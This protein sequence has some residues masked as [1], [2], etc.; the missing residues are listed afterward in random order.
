MHIPPL[1]LL[2]QVIDEGKLGLLRE[3][4]SQWP[5][6]SVTLD[7]MEMVFAKADPRVAE[8]YEMM[9]VD[10]NL[11]E[12]GRDLRRCGNCDASMAGQQVAA[13]TAEKYAP[14]KWDLCR[15]SLRGSRSSG[16]CLRLD[17]R[18]PGGRIMPF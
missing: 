13:C 15:C 3:M 16:A 17:V 6:F 18:V 12:F 8:F 11:W 10:K 9:L 7:M 2:Q 1:A 4:Y 5:F 14:F